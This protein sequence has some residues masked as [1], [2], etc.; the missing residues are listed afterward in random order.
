MHSALNEIIG[1][2]VCFTVRVFFAFTSYQDNVIRWLKGTVKI[3]DLISEGKHGDF[4]F[5]EW[6]A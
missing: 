5:T 1:L 3:K 4:R 6:E 2:V